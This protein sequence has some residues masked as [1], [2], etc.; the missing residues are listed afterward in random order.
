MYIDLMWRTKRAPQYC[1]MMNLPQRKQ[2][3]DENGKLV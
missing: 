3:G 1:G 2:Q